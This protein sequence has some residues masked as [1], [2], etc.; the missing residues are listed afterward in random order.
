MTLTLAQI[1]EMVIAALSAAATGELVSRAWPLA[2]I[3]RFGAP[4]LAAILAA[5][6]AYLLRLF[7]T[8][9]IGL[10]QSLGIIDWASVSATM[11]VG[12]VC[13]AI[14]IFAVGVIRIGGWSNP[15]R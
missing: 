9:G 6:F 4:I 13:G 15:R 7:G 8:D 12:A 3:K 11:I 5:P 14:F 10:Q 1:I 2:R